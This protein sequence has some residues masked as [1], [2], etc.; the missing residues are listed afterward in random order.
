MSRKYVL[1]SE[2]KRNPMDALDD[3]NDVLCHYDADTPISPVMITNWKSGAALVF[4]AYVTM[5][6]EQM[7]EESVADEQEQQD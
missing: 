6:S 7:Q 5:E 1:R 3:L 4:V 2:G